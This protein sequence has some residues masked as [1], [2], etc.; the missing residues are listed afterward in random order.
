[1]GRRRQLIVSDYHKQELK[2]LALHSRSPKIRQ[3]C[4]IVLLNAAGFTNVSIQSELG[5]CSQTITS[6][7]DRYELN[8]PFQGLKC[9][10]NLKGGGR[11][12]VL[13]D[14]DKALVISAIQEERQRL[15][16]AKTIIESAKGVKLSD[17]Q[18]RLF[19]KSLVGS[20]SE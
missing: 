6:V 5:C 15:T 11:K 8:Y 7:L 19:L 16:L 13:Q 17:Y 2:Y 3:R 20:I 12:A 10:H 18:V 1:M 14:E 4:N 9:L